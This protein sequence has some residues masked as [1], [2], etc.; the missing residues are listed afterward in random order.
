MRFGFQDSLKDPIFPSLGLMLTPI[1]K[2]KE[3]VN[4]T[5]E[6]PDARGHIQTVPGEVLRTSCLGQD[7]GFLPVLGARSTHKT[8]YF[9]VF[10]TFAWCISI[11]I[12]TNIT[13]FFYIAMTTCQA[14][15]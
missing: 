1:K 3:E 8:G 10:P 4:S 6:F 14:R 13:T 2:M 12:M 5:G 7:M 15:F 11:T 9:Q